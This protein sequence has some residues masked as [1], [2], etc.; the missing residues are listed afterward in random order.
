MSSSNPWDSVQP[1]AAAFV[2]AKNVA[3]GLVTQENMET[4]RKDLSC[5]THLS[6]VEKVG[7]LQAEMEEKTL[8]LDL[9]WLQQE[10][11]DIAHPYYLEKKLQILQEMN[12]HLESVLKE[13]R[14]LRQRLM[15]PLCQESLAI[16][17]SFHRYVAELLKMTV[18]FIGKLD[19]YLETIKTI[20]EMAHTMK[21]MDTAVAKMT[22]LVIETEELVKHVQKWRDQHQQ[23]KNRSF[24]NLL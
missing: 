4:I 2:L 24:I 11:A 14:S 21:E 23:I 13:K 20:P 19:S 12:S 16:E 1:T 5:F 18:T 7:T 6:K 10:V 17:A 3:C 9:L 22:C 8:E 15:K